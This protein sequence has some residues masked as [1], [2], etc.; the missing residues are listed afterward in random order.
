[1]PYLQL[2][3]GSGIKEWSYKPA[4]QFS[5]TLILTIF[6]VPLAP[7][8]LG[9]Q[10]QS[11]ATFSKKLTFG[12]FLAKL[13][14][15]SWPVLPNFFNVIP[16]HAELSGVNKQNQGTYAS[17]KQPILPAYQ[18]CLLSF[19]GYPLHQGLQADNTYEKGAKFPSLPLGA[20]TCTSKSSRE[21]WQGFKNVFYNSANACSTFIVKIGA[22]LGN[23]E[24]I[25]GTFFSLHSNAKYSSWFTHSVSQNAPSAHL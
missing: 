1:M 6:V 19:F 25:P 2:F 21:V 4:S 13:D 24:L 12:L 11:K 5:H 8:F 18:S 14:T 22:H 17:P 20:T 10:L 23:T 15:F 9:S 3:E 16:F 7:C